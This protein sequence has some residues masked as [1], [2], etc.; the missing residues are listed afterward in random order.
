MRWLPQFSLA[1]RE[2][3]W[4]VVRKKMAAQGLDALIVL[5]TDIFWGMGTA[6]VQYLCHVESQPG[7]EALF[8]IEG[9]PVVWA[10]TPHT[11]WPGNR[12]LST[13]SWC[14]DL[15]PRRGMRAVAEEASERGLG[16]ARLGLVGYTSAIQTTNVL[17]RGDV[18]TLE[19]LLPQA[20]FVD[21]SELLVEARLVKSEEEID[22][23]RR[24]G[25]VARATLDAMVA[26]ACPGATEAD[27]Y[28]EMARSQI[29]NGG[30]PALFVLLGSGP[31]EH[32][33]NEWWN[34]LHGAEGPKSPTTRPLSAGDLVIA[35]WHTKY[36]GYRC[37]TEFSVY[38]GRRAPDQLLRIWD[39]AVECLEASRSALRAGNTVRD[40]VRE[41]RQPATRAGLDWVELGFHAM[42]AGSPEVP[43]VV[44]EEGFGP[45]MLNG[46]GTG[47]IVLE[48]G[49][50]FGNNIDLHD[51]RW[52]RDVGCMLADFMVVR[53]DRAEVL[54]DVP[55][56]LAQVG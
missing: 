51:G 11:A 44:Y 55:T 15:R 50:A 42:G 13:Q 39:V 47:D 6:N 9:D 10:A 33:D 23:L 21:A 43:T 2:R 56:E 38:L 52:K 27:V 22:M 40:A 46:E 17:L 30:E 34:L 31:V 54:V 5:G 25:V 20:Q 29:A 32:S 1:E 35:E 19:A 8:P 45:P 28:A 41:I 12:N 4:T 16:D 53:P 26:S 36:G 49:M 18:A 3:R 14:N 48:E 7:C 24:A 37:H